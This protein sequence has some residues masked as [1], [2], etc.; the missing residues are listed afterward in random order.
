MA[1]K[2]LQNIPEGRR[3]RIIIKL[4]KVI[5]KNKLHEIIRV[6]HAG[7]LGAIMIYDGQKL[8]FQLKRDPATYKLV[9]E[10]R[11]QEEAHLSY[12][13]NKIKT[14]RVRPTVMQPI[15]KVAGFGLG[16]A[17]GL[18]GRKTAMAVTVA[19]EEVID[20][21][22]QQQLE[23]LES[24]S[25]LKTKIA[26]FRQDELHHRDL[27]YDNKAAEMPGFMP[28]RAAVKCA[29]KFAISISSKI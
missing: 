23:Q 8:A 26:E 18:L 12:F 1:V 25:E 19:V 2:P 17:S 22:Y 16:L 9:A 5:K 15:W 7:E 11:R 21:H 27:G 6:D 29:T 10:M 28:F 14:E 20:E 3:C 13:D 24:A 4:L